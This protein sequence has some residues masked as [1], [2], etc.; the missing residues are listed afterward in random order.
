MNPKYSNVRY[1]T[2]S[3]RGFTPMKQPL[4]SISWQDRSLE[5]TQSKPL[6]LES[7]TESREI[8]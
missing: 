7:K 4:L 8:A 2:E 5:V 1:E 3:E 6:R